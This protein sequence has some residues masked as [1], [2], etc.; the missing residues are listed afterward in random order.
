MLQQ[1]PSPVFTKT[2]EIGARHLDAFG[3]RQRAAVDAVEA[4]GLHVVRKAAR[5]A[6]AGDEDGLFRPQVLVAA[7]PLHGGEDRVVA[8]A[9]APARH[10]A[11]VVLELVVLFVHAQQAF[12]GGAW[13]C[14]ESSTLHASFAESTRRSYLV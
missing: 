12:G 7:Q 1:S 13:S 3:D 11:L 6:D 10:A 4:V 5:A 2:C 8:A 9:G 14:G